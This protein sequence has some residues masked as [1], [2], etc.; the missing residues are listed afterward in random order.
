MTEITRNRIGY[1][2]AECRS[3]ASGR[4]ASAKFACNIG[5]P[6]SSTLCMSDPI[7]RLMVEVHVSR[8]D[9]QPALPAPQR[10]RRQRPPTLRSIRE[11]LVDDHYALLMAGD[12]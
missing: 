9:R 11:L 7:W 12:Y 4:G 2:C 6:A 8:R 10:P 1:M 3:P 5:S